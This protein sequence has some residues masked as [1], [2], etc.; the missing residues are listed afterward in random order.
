MTFDFLRLVGA[1]VLKVP[2]LVTLGEGED[3]AG[4]ARCWRISCNAPANESGTVVG[5]GCGAGASADIDGGTR[6]ASA[7]IREFNGA[8]TSSPTCFRTSSMTD[9]KK[10]GLSGVDDSPNFFSASLWKGSCFAESLSEEASTDDP[11][12]GCPFFGTTRKSGMTL[13]KIFLRNSST[14]GRPESSSEE[15]SEDVPPSLFCASRKTDWMICMPI[16]GQ[17]SFSG[18]TGSGSALWAAPFVPFCGIWFDET[19]VPSCASWV[20]TDA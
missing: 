9:D 18:S 1:T 15:R 16:S 19:G 14:D 6:L 13:S 12:R 20:T 8:R 3:G 17:L 10:S 5:D 7:S 11:F 2:G 4:L